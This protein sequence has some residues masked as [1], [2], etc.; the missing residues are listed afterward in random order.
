MA[1][2]VTIGSRSIT[3]VPDGSANFDASVLQGSALPVGTVAGTFTVGETVT[4]AS[5]GATGVVQSWDPARKMLKLA[6]MTG[7]FNTTNTITGGT[8]LATAIPTD[9]YTPF[10]KGLRLSAIR[11]VGSQAMDR[12]IVREDRATGPI[13]FNRVDVGG[14]GVE[15]RFDNPQRLSPYILASEQT[16]NTAASVRII[17]EFD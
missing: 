13:I 3:I 12:L 17:L 5:S 9:I 2:A 8:S 6:S 10:A 15:A 14:G 16:W 11:F 7:T 4:Q 1:N